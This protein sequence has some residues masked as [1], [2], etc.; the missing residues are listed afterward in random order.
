MA[1]KP[2]LYGQIFVP[3]FVSQNYEHFYATPATGERP[4]QFQEVIV[5]PGNYYPN[6]ANPDYVKKRILYESCS[7]I[8]VPFDVEVDKDLR[9][10]MTTDFSAVPGLNSAIYNHNNLHGYFTLPI[11]DLDFMTS[12]NINGSNVLNPYIPYNYQHPSLNYFN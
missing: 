11:G 4:A 7:P 6:P 2:G 12:T 8:C 1:Q 10:F 9:D 5:H 3:A